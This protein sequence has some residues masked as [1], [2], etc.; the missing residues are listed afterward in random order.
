MKN[1]KIKL[2]IASFL[3]LIILT[4]CGKEPISGADFKKKS[5]DSYGMKISEDIGSSEG[6]GD[7][8]YKKVIKAVGDDWTA[9]YYRFSSEEKA[10]KI[11]EDLKDDMGETGKQKKHYQKLTST[12]KTDDIITKD[13]YGKGIDMST[14]AKIYKVAARVE[15]TIIYV[16]SVPLTI[17]TEDSVPGQIGG[18]L[19][20][21]G[22][23]NI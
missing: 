5:E 6:L 15:D 8:K 4:G 11:M 23:E 13:G 12:E 16:V 22:Y 19:Q 7:I 9:Y 17:E 18:Y 3:L 21:M 1:K 2:L 10:I 20:V 14:S